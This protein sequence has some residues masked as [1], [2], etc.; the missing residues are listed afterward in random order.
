MCIEN[1]GKNLVPTT[2]L[3]LAHNC[4]YVLCQ[5]KPILI[6]SLR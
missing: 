4:A 5:A 2:Y 3:I 1:F 6:V